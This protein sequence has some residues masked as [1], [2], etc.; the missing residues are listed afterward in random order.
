MGGG[1]DDQLSIGTLVERPG[2]EM[3]IAVDVESQRDWRGGAMSEP[4][5]MDGSLEVLDDS[6]AATVA[7]AVEIDGSLLSELTG[8][9]PKP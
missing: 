8:S 5:S 3:L 2:S 4:A 6:V 9:R 1:G 7:I